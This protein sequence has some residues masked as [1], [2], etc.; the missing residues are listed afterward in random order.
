MSKL[1]HAKKISRRRRNFKS[2]YRFETLSKEELQTRNH[3][4]ICLDLEL[5]KGWVNSGM[6]PLHFDINHCNLLAYN[7]SIAVITD[8]LN[9]IIDCSKPELLD[10]VRGRQFENARRELELWAE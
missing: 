1:S 6:D 3:L 10:Y 9:R 4:G 5:P 8:K 7:E 2:N